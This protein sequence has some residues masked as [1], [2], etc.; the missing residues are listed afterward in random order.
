MREVHSDLIPSWTDVPLSQSGVIDI[1]KIV[2]G[3]ATIEE[4]LEEAIP[5]KEC[6]ICFDTFEEGDKIVRLDC[7][8]IY[9]KDCAQEW[10]DKVKQTACPVHQ[11]DVT[12]KG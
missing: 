10:F 1:N 11:R 7:W 4:T 2:V 6:T 12:P 5:D 9:H 8:C 3:C